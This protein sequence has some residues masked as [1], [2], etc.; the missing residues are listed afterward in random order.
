MIKYIYPTNTRHWPDV[1]IMLVHRLRHWP[2]IITASG[3]CLVSAWSYVDLAKPRGDI[4]FI[5]TIDV[6]FYFLLEPM[7]PI[8]PT[9]RLD[10]AGPSGLGLTAS[11]C[12]DL[13]WGRWC[14]MTSPTLKIWQPKPTNQPRYLCGIYWWAD[15][16]CCR[17]RCSRG[18]TN[19]TSI[20]TNNRQLCLWQYVQSGSPAIRMPIRSL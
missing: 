8:F 13:L 4:S 14:F 5:S 1:V 18:K 7:S 17:R 2:S 6:D 3:Q 19:M 15:L 9:A 10:T 12:Q 11:R 16:A 20:Q